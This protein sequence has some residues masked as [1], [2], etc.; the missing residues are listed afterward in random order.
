MSAVLEADARFC[1]YICAGAS[2]ISLADTIDSVD[3]FAAPAA[4]SSCH[5]VPYTSMG[6]M[7]QARHMT[8]CMDQWHPHHL[9]TR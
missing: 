9:C 2:T 1:T 4:H 3:R 6:G 8:A 7:A 5:L